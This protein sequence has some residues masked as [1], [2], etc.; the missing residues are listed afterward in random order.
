M[1]PIATT[2][3]QELMGCLTIVIGMLIDLPGLGRVV[4]GANVSDQQFDWTKNYRVPDLL[5]FLPRRRP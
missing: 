5:V 2:E 1:E 3:H 4:P